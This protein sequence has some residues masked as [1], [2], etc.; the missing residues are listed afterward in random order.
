M[1]RTADAA[2][3]DYTIAP[4]GL[5]RILFDLPFYLWYIVRDL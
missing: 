5:A 2:R 1:A 4:D 3:G